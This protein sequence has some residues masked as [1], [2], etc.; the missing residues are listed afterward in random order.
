MMMTVLANLNA[1]SGAIHMLHSRLTLLLA[2][3]R[4]LEQSQGTI[5]SSASDTSPY[6]LLR[7]LSALTTRLSL[8]EPPPTT[9]TSLQH[10]QLAEQS[11]VL[12]TAL[13]GYMTKS[14]NEVRKVGSKYAVVSKDHERQQ[15]MNVMD[16]ETGGGGGGGNN[17]GNGDRGGGLG[18]R[19]GMG[20][21]DTRKGVIDFIRKF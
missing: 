10:E 15:A 20:L 3:L 18:G 1:K 6:P 4:T 5:T 16:I 2:Y 21:H 12:L 14:I 9:D 7:S 13:L 11:D 8:L 19:F 17:N